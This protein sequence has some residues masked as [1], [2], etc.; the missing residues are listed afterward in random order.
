MNEFLSTY[1]QEYG[2]VCDSRILD[3]R[4]FIKS[5]YIS[6]TLIF[7]NSSISLDPYYQYL[8]PHWSIF[9]PMSGNVRVLN[10]RQ[11]NGCQMA[12]LLIPNDTV[13]CFVF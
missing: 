10:Y 3:Y 13:I 11:L 6:M 2:S 5:D 1:V 9:W 12:S 8:S 4:V 7:Q